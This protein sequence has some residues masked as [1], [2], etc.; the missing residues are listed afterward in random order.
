M[1]M[2]M[3]PNVRKAALLTHV[4]VSVGWIGALAVFL[5]HAAANTWTEHT[6]TVRALSIAMGVTAWFVILPL[7]VLSVVTGVVQ[8]L[9][10]PWGLRRH[11]WVLFKLALTCIATGVLLLKIG[12]I[13]HLAHSAKDA[14]FSGG[15]L[16]ALRTSL[17][18][19]AVGGMVVLMAIAAL[20]IFKPRGLTVYGCRASG[21]PLESAPRWVK[22]W[23]VGLFVLAA[24][25]AVMVLGGGHGPATHLRSSSTSDASSQL[26]GI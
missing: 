25:L 13:E 9:G 23:V 3:T 12:P 19:H 24:V 20:A 17:F 5:V 16:L 18:V 10:T 21:H 4:S 6:Q 1:N 11:Y 26:Q 14:A 7:S 2:T 15:D 22:R 8:A